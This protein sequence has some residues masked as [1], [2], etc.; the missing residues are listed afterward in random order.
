MTEQGK[1]SG[2]TWKKSKEKH[3]AWLEWQHVN[4]K[5]HRVVLVTKNEQM[6]LIESLTEGVGRIAVVSWDKPS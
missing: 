1:G 6:L 3:G 5:K 2:E 4:E